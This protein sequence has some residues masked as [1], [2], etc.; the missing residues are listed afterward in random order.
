MAD[1]KDAGMVQWFDLTVDDASGLRDFYQEVT[2]WDFQ[3][4]SVGDYEDWCMMAGDQLVT[5]IC[6]RKGVN[7]NMPPMWM[8]YINVENLEHSIQV[9][10][11]RGG[12]VV[13]GPRVQEGHGKM[14]VIKDPA[15][16]V[17]ALFEKQ[18]ISET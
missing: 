10:T 18:I 12:H 7:Q 1:S 17:C 9:C 13:D 11:D 16:A 14:A 4:A 2:G 5:G 8:I 15:G 3:P 6:H